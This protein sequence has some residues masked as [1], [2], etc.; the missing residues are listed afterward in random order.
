MSAVVQF[1]VPDTPLTPPR[2]RRLR[3]GSRALSWLF[4]GLIGV[5][6]LVAA[7]LIAGVVFYGG[8]NYRI[9]AGAVW[10]GE[11]SPDSVAFHTLT[12]PHRLVYAAVGVSRIP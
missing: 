7:T 1:P 11:G 3:L 8:E 9:G 10:I 12:L 4:T 6:G 2:L 5:V